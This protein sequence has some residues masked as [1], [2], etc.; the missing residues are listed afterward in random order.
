MCIYLNE[1]E[2]YILFIFV[3][4]TYTLVLQSLHNYF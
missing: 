3:N 2:K 1:T 4:I